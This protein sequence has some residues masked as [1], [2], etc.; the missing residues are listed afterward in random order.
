MI[1]SDQY[2]FGSKF[3]LKYR[4]IYVQKVYIMLQN[5]GHKPHILR[6]VIFQQGINI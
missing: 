3:K 5:V 1:Y 6:Y 4:H 2:S